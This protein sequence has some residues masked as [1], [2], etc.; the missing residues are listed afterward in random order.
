M[1][2]ARHSA[3]LAA[4]PLH[5]G[6][7]FGAVTV[8]VLAAGVIVLA[9]IAGNRRPQQPFNTGSRY[10]SRTPQSRP[11]PRTEEHLGCTAPLVNSRSTRNPSRMTSQPAHNLSQTDPPPPD[12][13][14]P[15]HGPYPSALQHPALPSSPRTNARDTPFLVG[16]AA[17]V[18][19]VLGGIACL[20]LIA[21]VATDDTAAEAA[22]PLAA[23]RPGECV[24]IPAPHATGGVPATVLPAHC[25]TLPANFRVLQTG[26]CTD[27]RVEREH[28]QTGRTGREQ[29]HL[30]LAPDWQAG[31]CYDVTD[32][33]LPRKVDCAR[34]GKKIIRITAVLPYTAGADACPRDA[35]GSNAV[36][37]PN[38][39]IT[40]C[41]RGADRPDE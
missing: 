22:E 23:T 19:A 24:A 9:M 38:R 3:V 8:T 37:W 27:P 13:A 25:D 15:R 31:V 39:G 34:V 17:G 35:D 2:H 41:M 28:R 40:L 11:E 18:V 32:W 26:T 6:L 14:S 7:L 36:G 21:P 29:V 10:A 30:C 33:Q 20:V 1:T 12:S 5:T 4:A 16:A